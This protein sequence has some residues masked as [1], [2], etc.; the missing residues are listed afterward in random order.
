M[1][2]QGPPDQTVAALRS[3]GSLDVL[4]EARERFRAC[5]EWEGTFRPRFL[6][7]LKFAEA[8]AFNGYQWP[9]SVRRTRD[10]SDKPCLTLNVVR[11]HNLKI[12]NDMRKAKESCK[13]LGMGN[14][15]TQESAEVVKQ[16]IRHIEYN[17]KAQRNAYT[18][19]RG[20]QVKGGIGWWR[21]VTDYES[22]DSFDQ[23]I[24]IK[25]VPDP[26]SV[27]MDPDCQ[28]AD[29]SDARY[30]FIFSFM[31]RELIEALVPDYPWQMGAPRMPIG[32][33]PG[34]SF[35]IEKDHWL[36]AEYFRKVPVQDQLISF[37]TPMGER[38]TIRKSRI[39][40][41]VASRLREDDRTM[42]R[43]V[44]DQ[45]I[46][47]KLIVGD[48]IVDETIWPGKY[49]PLVR[50]IGEETVIEGI[51][52]RKGHT[53]ALTDAQRMFNYNAELSLNTAVPILGGWKTVGELKEGDLV[54]RP[55]GTTTPIVELLPIHLDEE[56]FEIEFDN[57]QKVTTDAGHIW[58]VEERAGRVTAGFVWEDVTVCTAELIPGKHFIHV[59]KPLELPARNDLSIKPY[60][61]GLWL[62]DGRDGY[63]TVD[64]Q[65]FDEIS[66]LVAG[67]LEVK[68]Q[69]I[70]YVPPKRIKE[71]YLRGSY[72]QRLAL[73][74][75]LM[76]ADGHFHKAT[77]SCIYMKGD[78]GLVKDFIELCSSLGIKVF[79]R[80]DSA[81]Q[82]LWRLHFT[83]D[84][85]MPVFRLQRK[86]KPQ[87]QG[88]PTHW[89]RTKRFGIKHI[90]A[91]ESVPVRCIKLDTPD[92]LFLVTRSMIPT[93]NS[94]SIE[95]GA[96]QTK[97]PWLAAAAAIEGLEG[98]WNTANTENHSVLV[99]KH[100]DD[101]N[102]EATIPPPQKIEPP[103][104]SPAFETGMQTAFQQMMM[105]S[106]QWSNQQ[107][108]MGNERTG[109][110]IQERLREGE[111]ATYHF[112]DNYEDA[113]VYTY[114]QII[115]LIPKVYDTRR[116]KH[117]LA[118][119]GIEMEIELDP[120]AQQPYMQSLDRQGEI[121]RRVLNPTMG[122]YEVAASIGPN[123]ES[124]RAEAVE[125]LTQIL[126]EAPALTAIIG[127]ILLRNMDFDDA[128]EA[129][130]RLRRMVPPQALGQGP[131]QNEQQLAQQ[132]QQLQA[133]LAK[134]LEQHGKDAIKLAGKD[135]M[136]D[137]DVYSAETD[138]IKALAAM[139]PTDP[140]GLRQLIDQLVNDSLETN[141]L[142][143]IQQ[144]Q[145]E[146]HQGGTEDTL[147]GQGGGSGDEEGG[148]G[149]EPEKPPIP[150]ASKGVDGEWYILDPTRK[151]RYLRIGPLA[152][153]RTPPG[154]ARVGSQG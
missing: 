113:L 89:R 25:G 153:E 61:Y 105:T 97:S 44:V 128:Q 110:A 34:E 106:G 98:L 144:N 21:I 12:I 19:A 139:L 29:C 149:S 31:P 59:T 109:T 4:E 11:Q 134:A 76:D 104:A 2:G 24:F 26:L 55:D 80:R 135:Q 13:I 53:R 92:H 117:I 90:R 87:M 37:L 74:Q 49:I 42:V 66:N 60:A 70:R 152:Q 115:D 79:G 137:I 114:Q 56:C 1:Q 65:D 47:W 143:I 8:D 102:A 125:D 36:V 71:E 62:G 118:D 20:F 68:V 108:Q 103:S 81:R 46:E 130:M 91:V 78:S 51:L 154:T 148:E 131:S 101:D 82:G 14:G 9:D 28:E 136:R 151:T 32:I 145:E 99:W 124:K 121:V 126:T 96:L 50:C 41:E 127:D 6:E 27:Y 73:L 33:A 120:G 94:A 10:L 132:V 63:I 39:P 17:S 40:D 150:G 22:N 23:E 30:A 15:A 5:S 3:L 86:L 84:P 122:T 58:R 43:N 116:V 141:L 129:A 93:H 38:I 75:G 83:V 111:S 133:N 77:N 18:P 112:T 7:D 35:F 52:D 69:D 119:D 54:F 138:R 45:Q 57:G 100:V 146:W 95:F 67:E 48:E 64:K 72:E 16:L 140:E 88:R 85:D 107:G 142:P 147:G 123:V